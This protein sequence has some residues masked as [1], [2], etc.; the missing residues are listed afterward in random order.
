MYLHYKVLLIGLKRP[1]NHTY[2]LLINPYSIFVEEK[3]LGIFLIHSLENLTKVWKNE[4][5]LDNETSNFLVISQTPSI[6]SD[7]FQK[8]EIN[9]YKSLNSKLSGHIIVKSTLELF[10]L[11]VKE[12]RI[13]S[14]KPIVLAEDLDL[15]EEDFSEQDQVFFN[16]TC[17]DNEDDILKLGLEDADYLVLFSEDDFDGTNLRIIDYLEEKYTDLQYIAYLLFKV[18]VCC[19]YFIFF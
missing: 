4:S 3:D 6:L 12:I 9:E 17:W 14:K 7:V 18:L 1:I 19:C 2:D 10:Q 5:I 8:N 16:R 11:F 15:V 13:H